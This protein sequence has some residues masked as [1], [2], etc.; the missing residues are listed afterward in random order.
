MPYVR[1]RLLVSLCPLLNLDLFKRGFYHIACS[2]TDAQW[3]Q[4]QSKVTC[5]EVKDLLGPG[6]VD[7]G[8]PGACVME[9]HFLTH[10][11]LIEY[12]DQSFLI[13]EGFLFEL[14][15]PLR[16]DYTEAYVPAHLQLHL[17]LMFS[18]ES[19]MPTDPASFERVA[20]R[21]VSI[22]V[23]WRKGIHDHWPVIFDYY[24]LCAVG[25][26][27][28]ASL[29]AISPDEFPLL[30]LPSPATTRRS[31][32]SQQASPPT[33]HISYPS[34]LFGVP[35]ST[36]GRS[37]TYEVSD[38]QV[39]RAS[40]AHQMLVDMLFTSRDNL[41]ASFTI[42][43]EEKEEDSG[44]V[45]RRLELAGTFSLEDI[46]EKCRQHMASLSSKLSSTWEWFCRCAVSHPDMLVYLAKRCHDN[47]LIW[48]RMSVVWPDSLKKPVDFTSTSQLVSTASTVR[49]TITPSLPFFCV[50]NME[51]SSNGSV[52]FLERCPWPCRQQLTQDDPQQRYTYQTK[53]SPYLL[54]SLPTASRHRPPATH[55]IVCVHGLQGNQFDLR[56]YRIYL[57]MALPQQRLMFLMSHANQQDTFTDFNTMTDRLQ[58]ELLEFLQDAP[59]P[60]KISFLA[61]SLGGIVVRSLIT[62]PAVAHLISRLHL[63]VSFC[64][65]HLGT[66]SQ[67]GVVSAGMWVVRKWYQSMSLLQ[68]SLKD[69]PDVRDCFLYH[70][71]EAPSLEYFS[72]VVLISSPQDRYV[73]HQS[74]QLLTGS[75]SDNT[76]EEMCANLLRGMEEG[77]VELVRVMVHHA[78]HTSP[79][80]IIGRAAHI[81][82]LDNELFVEKLVLCHIVQYFMDSRID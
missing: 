49:Q 7:H 30:L 1:S 9:D 43:S 23:D 57:E 56:L 19:E 15:T 10:T 70:L 50:E 38:Q 66:Q 77:G 13:G 73:P 29:C 16:R 36:S 6:L 37:V 40:H 80:S 31:W 42:M 65:P 11:V 82:M 62:R 8:F 74:A 32:F 69:A 76:S 81:A 51:D 28:H 61:H 67:T 52:V 79:D 53:I 68:L 63:F 47:R 78:L 75:T 24:H 48:M 39:S 54:S 64:T 12:V 58:E 17:R 55:L 5:L 33:P 4:K 41:R 46:E 59:L 14:Q 71:S 3:E 26:T 2:L 27:V 72:H 34:M 20:S 45:P 22:T 18:G 44:S 60:S 21:T 35:S 25:V